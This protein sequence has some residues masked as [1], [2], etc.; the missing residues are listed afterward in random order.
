MLANGVI[1]DNEEGASIEVAERIS[2]RTD[3]L[4]KI[5]LKKMH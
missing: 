2:T 5:L 1:F 4:V 3:Q